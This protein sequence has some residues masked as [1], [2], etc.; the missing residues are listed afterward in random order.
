VYIEDQVQTHFETNDNANRYSAW[1]ELTPATLEFSVNTLLCKSQETPEEIYFRSYLYPSDHSEPNSVQ[2]TDW[3]FFRHASGQRINELSSN[4]LTNKRH[5]STRHSPLTTIPNNC[6]DPF[7]KAPC[8]LGAREFEALHH[9]K[10]TFRQAE[11]S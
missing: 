5:L 6:G 8:H 1:L 3:L 7:F 2:N 10:R 4:G 9:C 11:R